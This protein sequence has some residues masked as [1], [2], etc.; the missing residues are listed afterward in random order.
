MSVANENRFCSFHHHRKVHLPISTITLASVATAENDPE[1]K[2]PVITR[3]HTEPNSHEDLMYALG[4]NLARQLGD[5]R[6]LVNNGEELTYVA[7]GLLDAV[8][9]RLSEEGQLA[10]L[11]DRKE[12]I[13]NL[14]TERANKVREGII[15]AGRSMLETMSKIEG[16][17]TFESGVCLHV[18]EHGP[19]GPGKGTRPTAASTVKVHYHGTLSNGTIFD[20]TMIEDKPINIAIAA[21][22]NY[23]RV[24]GS[25]AQDA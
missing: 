8:V 17:E 9:G 16:V 19:E 4:V 5:I 12:D 15:A 22:R 14:I 13:N 1:R 25:T 7:K 23:S 2:E 20:S 18:L 11:K 3:A 21:S 24:E 6:P 10:L